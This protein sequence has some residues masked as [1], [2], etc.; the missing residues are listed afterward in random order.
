MFR[1]AMERVRSKEGQNQSEA[2][3]LFRC[4]RSLAVALGATLKKKRKRRHK[5]EEEEKKD[6]AI[7]VSTCVDNV[8]A[9]LTSSEGEQEQGCVGVRLRAL[10]LLLDPNL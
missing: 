8:L 1:L 7:F 2:N 5:E 3:F 10:G 9:L 6:G 4:F